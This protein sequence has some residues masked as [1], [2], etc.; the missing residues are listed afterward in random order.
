MKIVA[1]SD[2]HQHDYKNHSWTTGS[3][4]NS[5][6]EDV[7][8]TVSE[9]YEY[10]DLIGAPVI[11]GGDMF[12][13]KGSIPVAGFNEIYKIVSKRFKLTQPD[14]MIPGNH[15]MASADGSRHA[16][17]VFHDGTNLVID[18]PSV[19]SPW[20]N[21]VVAALPFPMK[22]GKFNIRKFVEGYNTCLSEVKDPKYDG[23]FRILVS[24]C[25][26]N[27]LMAKYLGIAGDISGKDLLEDYNF[28]LL[29]HHHIHDVI[30][31]ECG[32]KCVSIGA[33][34]QHTFN[35]VA[36][37]RGFIVINTE[38]MSVEHKPL[39]SRKFWA[40]SGESEISPEKAKGGFIRCR[41]SSKAEG[42]RARK[43]L[44]DAGAVSVVIELIPKTPVKKRLDLT[45]GA[46]DEEIIKKFID[47]E[48]CETE[49]HKPTLL[50]LANKYLEKSA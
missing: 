4:L 26:T 6:V 35:D 13:I 21:I 10:A 15:D 36:E 11:F 14:I 5:R 31:N 43:K 24:H 1:Y 22:N 9:V 25:F 30:D 46:K 2:P 40:F 38:T 29:G 33:P 12:Q 16:L 27:E 34:L 49:L 47:S 3:G 44:E 32:H 23:F 37:K 20:P 7:A 18:Q 42:D 45:T 50:T 39:Q 19:L 28:V 8:K 41:V 48:Y 17:E